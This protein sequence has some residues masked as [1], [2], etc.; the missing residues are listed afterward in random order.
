[1]RQ[2][3]IRMLSHPFTKIPSSEPAAAVVTGVGSSNS[4]ALG[5]VA[6]TQFT[7]SNVNWGPTTPMPVSLTAHA[8]VAI[9]STTTTAFLY[10]V[11]GNTD[12]ANAVAN[13]NTV[14]SA[15]LDA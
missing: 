15:T 13:V 12:G 14:R 7:S 2:T 5:L 8:A 11:G 4:V 10:V 6:T 1:M 3:T 9:E